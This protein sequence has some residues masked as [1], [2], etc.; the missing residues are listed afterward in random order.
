[1]HEH[2]PIYK[3]RELKLVMAEL[4]AQ[5]GVAESVKVIFVD[6]N[7]Y[8]IDFEDQELPDLGA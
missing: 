3:R 8:Y 2:E 7:V 6:E 4:V 5:R 1:M